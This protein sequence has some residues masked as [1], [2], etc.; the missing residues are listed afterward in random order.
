MDLQRINYLYRHPETYDVLSD[1]GRPAAKF[2]EE[3]VAAYAQPCADG[4][5]DLGCGTGSDLER[6][7]GRYR[8]TGVDIQPNMVAYA[9]RIRPDLDI[10]QGDIRNIR[11]GQTF[12]IVTCLGFAV[13]YCHSIAEVKAAF[14]TF[15]AHTRERALLVLN[16]PV[17]PQGDSED[18]MIFRIDEVGAR[19]E[20][21]Y[22][23]DLATQISTM[24]REW[25][26]DDGSKT[27]DRVRRRVIFPQELELYLMMAGFELLEVVGEGTDGKVLRG[28]AGYATARRTSLGCGQPSAE[29]SARA[30]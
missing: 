9:Q 17:A 6:L 3:R 12:D 11:L 21:T 1:V 28:P 25:T 10:R 8:C 26:F 5:L 30:R 22:E 4:L 18:T 27:R 15:A 19:V 13:S 14:A 16:L 23:W 29:G 24:N 20:V 2:V 7:S